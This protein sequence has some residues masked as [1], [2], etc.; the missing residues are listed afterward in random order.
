MGGKR[1][2][3]SRKSVGKV[4]EELMYDARKAQS[5]VFFQKR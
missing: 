1:M 3:R 2:A 4:V 5:A